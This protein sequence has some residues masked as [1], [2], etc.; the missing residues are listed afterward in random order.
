MRHVLTAFLAIAFTACDNLP[1]SYEAFAGD[2]RAV[3]LSGQPLPAELTR[4]RTAAGN[5]SITL[6]TG[7]MFTTRASGTSAVLVLEYA[8]EI[9]GP[10]GSEIRTF[11]DSDTM[12]VIDLRRR[13]I[14]GVDQ[15][16]WVF[17]DPPIVIAQA[18][19]PRRVSVWFGGNMHAVFERTR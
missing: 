10:S 18:P 8:V 5:D 6:L 12:P 3:S 16:E 17:G 15:F 9:R 2:Y 13:N 19:Q 11:E 7:G 4:H 1:T 14:D